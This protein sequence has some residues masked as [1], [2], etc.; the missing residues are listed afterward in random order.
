MNIILF[1][2]PGAGKGTQANNL[3]KNY[4]LFKVSTGDL[5][6]NEVKNRTALGVK[7][8]SVINKG[9]LVS[10]GIINDLITKILSDSKFAN[11]IVFDGYPR[12]LNQTKALERFGLI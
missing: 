5:L 10:D 2:P 4:N 8:E 3:I 11:R 1:G 7:I 12:N 9:S 6:R